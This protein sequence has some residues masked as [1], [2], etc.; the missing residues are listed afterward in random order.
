MNDITIK[1]L[2]EASEDVQDIINAQEQYEKDPVVCQRTDREKG[3]GILVVN[4]DVEFLSRAHGKICAQD[5]VEYRV[6]RSEMMR[7]MVNSD[8][9]KVDA[10]WVP[11]F[12]VYPPFTTLEIPFKLDDRMAPNEIRFESKIDPKLCDRCGEENTRFTARPYG[13]AVCLTCDE[14]EHHGGPR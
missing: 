4:P 8:G 12:I 3:R 11:P 6:L 9:E 2:L 1:R 7:G 10:F 14:K 5:G 13:I